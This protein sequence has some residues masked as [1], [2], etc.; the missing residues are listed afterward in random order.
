MPGG[1]A[2]LAKAKLPNT[3][4][5]IHPG[6]AEKKEKITTRFKRVSASDLAE[7]IADPDIVRKNGKS[8]RAGKVSCVEPKNGLELNLK[9]LQRARQIFRHLILRPDVQT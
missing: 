4:D 7:C 5:I 3:E 1:P 8:S 2:I 6:P 9:S